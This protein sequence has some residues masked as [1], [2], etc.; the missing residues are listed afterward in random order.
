M[1]NK[2]STIYTFNVK[3]MIKETIFKPAPKFSF[4]FTVKHIALNGTTIH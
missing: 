3:T 4:H 2:F 1:L